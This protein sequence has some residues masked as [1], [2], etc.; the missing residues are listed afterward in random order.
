M[1]DPTR[2]TRQDL[3]VSEPTG[4][5]LDEAVARGQF[6]AFRA[7]GMTLFD[8][9]QLRTVLQ[10]ALD[11]FVSTAEAKRLQDE[12]ALGVKD[13]HEEQLEERFQAGK[14]AMRVKSR[15]VE[16]ALEV[17]RDARDL[18]NDS[19]AWSGPPERKDQMVRRLDEFVAEL[20]S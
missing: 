12:V 4:D 14:D 18:V 10:A 5:E 19:L 7:F 20:E 8:D 17:L 15:Q 2:L 9:Q 6:A 11:G 3:G 1:T 13:A 16:D